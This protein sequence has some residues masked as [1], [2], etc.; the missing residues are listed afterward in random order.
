MKHLRY[1]RDTA[2]FRPDCNCVS[3]L[4][5]D[6]ELLTPVRIDADALMSLGD[7]NLDYSEVLLHLT[8][9]F[10]PAICFILGEKISRGNTKMAG[11]SCG[12]PTSS[13]SRRFRFC[14]K[15][16]GPSGQA[17]FGPHFAL[18]SPLS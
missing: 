8:H 14:S 13:S 11:Q 15:G 1:V 3:A 12:R 7:V 16:R 4:L 5:S 10:E 17:L 9:R 2:I 6:G 18:I